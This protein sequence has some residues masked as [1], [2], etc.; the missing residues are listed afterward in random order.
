MYSGQDVFNNFRGNR[1]IKA[2]ALVVGPF[3]YM[4]LLYLARFRI[5]V[6]CHHHKPV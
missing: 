4:T 6:N 1:Y 3:N 2:I 5:V